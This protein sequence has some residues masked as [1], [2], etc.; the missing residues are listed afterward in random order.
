[1]GKN[2][3]TCEKIFNGYAWCMPALFSISELQTPVFQKWTRDILK[4]AAKQKV[5]GLLFVSSK[6]A[7]AARCHKQ[8]CPLVSNTRLPDRS[9]PLRRPSNISRFP[10]PCHINIFIMTR[11][12]SNLNNFRFEGLRYAGRDYIKPKQKCD[13]RWKL[14]AQFS[15]S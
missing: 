3:Q 8:V 6:T 2:L 14:H 4:S 15:M 10:V 11:P 1:M 5:T 13:C 9:P 12:S 7:C